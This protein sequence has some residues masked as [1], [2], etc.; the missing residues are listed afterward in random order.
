MQCRIKE[1]ATLSGTYSVSGN[2]VTMNV[3]GNV[4]GI[5]SCQS[6]GNFNK[7]LSASTMTKTFVVKTMDSMFRPDK[8][9]ILCLD[10]AADEKCF[11]RDPKK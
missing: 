2:R 1:T 10:G 6:S 7:K 8:P 11:Q 5:N 3:S 9:T 4:V